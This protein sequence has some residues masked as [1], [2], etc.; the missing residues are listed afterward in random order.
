MM[1]GSLVEKFGDIFFE[2]WKC[3]VWVVRARFEDEREMENGSFGRFVK[4]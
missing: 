2:I 4:V 3:S 1:V